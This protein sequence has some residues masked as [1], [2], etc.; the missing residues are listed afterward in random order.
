MNKSFGDA[1]NNALLESFKAVLS[2]YSSD[3]ALEKAVRQANIVAASSAV[4]SAALIM[5]Q[6][7]KLFSGNEKLYTSFF[8]AFSFQT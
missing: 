6:Y 5:E 4:Q 8:E 2:I 7:N 3:P 1:Y